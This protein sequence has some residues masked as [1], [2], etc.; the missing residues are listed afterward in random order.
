MKNQRVLLILWLS[1]INKIRRQESESDDDEKL[2][3]YD[4]ILGA[5][6]T[7]MSWVTTDDR[8]KWATTNDDPFNNIQYIDS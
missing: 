6:N 5:N 4:S 3:L 1:E 8:S 2:F 7:N